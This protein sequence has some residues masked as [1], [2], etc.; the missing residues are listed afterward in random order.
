VAVSG[1]CQRLARRPLRRAVPRS[2]AR[3][4]DQEARSARPPASST[5]AAGKS[6]T[7]RYGWRRVWSPR[8]GQLDR[9][10]AGFPR[11][12]AGDCFGGDKFGRW[13]ASRAI[14]RLPSWASRASASRRS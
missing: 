2:D 10:D 12:P 8:T 6:R 14:G 5:P 9:S 1:R 13:P 4:Y 3:P 7:I 11:D